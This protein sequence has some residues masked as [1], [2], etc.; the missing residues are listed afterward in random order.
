MDKL[1]IN[2]INNSLITCKKCCLSTTRTNAVKGEGNLNAKIFFIAQAPG[3]IEDKENKMLIGPSGKIFDKLFN[4][5][6]ISRKDVY[7]SNIIKCYL[8]NCRKPRAEELDIC[9]YNYL[10]KE[11][12]IVKPKILIPLGYHVTKYILK[13]FD[14]PIPNR[15]EFPKLFGKLLISKNMQILPLRHPAMVVHNKSK[16]SLLEKNYKKINILINK[17]K[18][19]SECPIIDYY[20]SGKIIKDWVDLYC[21]GNW[22]EC[23]RYK[24]YL[25]RNYIP[26]NM[27]PDGIIDISLNNYC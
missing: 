26:D 3:H 24:N 2:N 7:I 25:Q 21:R 27:L 1:E 23:Q 6:T 13:Q 12:Q 18:Y 8:P 20:Q 19:Y 15:H 4:E 9:Y 22:A 11:I 10:A 14:L 16:Y 17:C 5:L